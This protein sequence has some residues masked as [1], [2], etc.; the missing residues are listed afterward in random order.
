MNFIPVDICV[1]GM[2]I[3]S[4]DVWKEKRQNDLPPVYN[5]ASI[6]IVKYEQLQANREIPKEYPSINALGETD[7]TFTTCA[8]YAWIIRI[9]R[10][11][12]P[13][14]IIDTLLRISNQKPRYDWQNGFRL[15]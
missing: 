2:I 1:K 7:T 9:F 11:L 10:N 4:Y 12:I 3:A 8:F 5:A 13:A 14:V 6:N 15:N